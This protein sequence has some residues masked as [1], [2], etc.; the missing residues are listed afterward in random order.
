MAERLDPVVTPPVAPNIEALQELA[1]ARAA[2]VAARVALARQ[3]ETTGTPALRTEL[4]RQIGNAD[5]HIARLEQMIDAGITDDPLLA[6]RRDIL[7]SIPGIGQITA[8]TLIASFAELG[9]LTDKQA[10][11]LAG[12]APHPCDSGPVRGKRHIRSGRPGVRAALYMA[13][14]SAARYNPDLAAFSKRLRDNGKPPKVALIAVARKLL[15][16]ANAL[17]NQNRTWS[18]IHP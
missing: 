8:T 10:A 16:L 13:A 18:K 5:R 14:L 3:H 4:A 17:I 2:A 6:R 11:A 9:S 1:S 12:L 15:T 7:Q